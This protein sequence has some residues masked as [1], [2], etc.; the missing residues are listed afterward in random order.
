MNEIFREHVE[1]LHPS[2]QKLMGT[3]P[4]K[5]CTLPKGMPSRGVYL[6]S[7]GEKHWYVGRTNRLRQRLQEHWRRSSTHNSAPF[8]FLLARRMTGKLNAS[9]QAV[10]SRKQLEADPTFRA[11]FVKAKIRVGKMDVSFIEEC[12]PLRQALLEMYVAIA[13]DTQYNSFENH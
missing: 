10:G 4:V 11:A 12:D 7:E 8:A 13:L 5:V 6:F 1:S 9:Y 2:F 3:K